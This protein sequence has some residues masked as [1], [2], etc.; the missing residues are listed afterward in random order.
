MVSA[1]PSGSPRPLS[2][3]WLDAVY[4]GYF[5]IHIPVTL[6]LDLQSIYPAAITPA[7]FRAIPVWYVGFSNDPLIAGAMGLVKS[8]PTE[9]AWLKSF[10]WLEVVFQLPLFFWGAYGLWKDS[11]SVYVPILIYGASTATTTLACVALV[12]GTSSTSAATIE[13]GI[14]SV[15]SAQRAKLLADYLP[16]L[17]LPLLM[18]LDIGWRMY[19][20]AVKGLKAEQAI[21]SK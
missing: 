15:T 2:S 20:L 6:L 3:R 21:K 1:S 5:L 18:V 13:A 16:F 14:A 10:M 19:G 4:V 17:F 8:T 9:F 12:L 11:F 7:W